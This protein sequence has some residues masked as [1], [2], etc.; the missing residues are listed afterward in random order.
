MK[1]FIQLSLLG[2]VVV[3]MG[4][5][6]LLSWGALGVQTYR[7]GSVEASYDALVAAGKAQEEINKRKAE[8]D[9][10]LKREK[11]NEAKRKY[12]ALD[13][14][15]KRLLASPFS[16][17]VPAAE[18]SGGA[19]LACFDRAQFT[20][21]LN[22]FISEVAGIAQSGDQATIGLDIARGWVGELLRR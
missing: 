9:A 14:R 13:D 20:G 17:N 1:G 8:G 22:Q 12:A 19:D 11:D 7:L 15:Y 21:A 16:V 4:A 2:Y 10:K 6:L 18:S 3:G 5:A